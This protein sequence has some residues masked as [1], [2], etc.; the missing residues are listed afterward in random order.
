MGPDSLSPD[1]NS[2]RKRWR[3]AHVDGPDD[4]VLPS[5]VLRFVG[6]RKAR[7]FGWTNTLGSS[8]DLVLF[9]ILFLP[10]QN[11]FKRAQAPHSSGPST[12]KTSIER[13]APQVS[14]TPG[15]AVSKRLLQTCYSP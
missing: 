3:G 7:I 8:R 11:A 14:R 4:R 6:P 13:P 5:L 15:L 9:D 1:S 2:A 10:Q 12:L